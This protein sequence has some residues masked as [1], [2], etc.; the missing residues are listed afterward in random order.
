MKSLTLTDRELSLV[1]FALWRMA[2]IAHGNAAEAGQ[3]KANRF[4]KK[5]DCERWMDDARD[6]EQL[7][8]RV[9]AW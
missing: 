8:A 4:T 3:D 7:R 1:G 9:L 6:C 5:G 2:E